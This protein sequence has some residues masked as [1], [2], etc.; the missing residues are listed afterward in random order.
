M[1]I[2]SYNYEQINVL[3]IIICY[4]VF[5]VLIQEELLEESTFVEKGNRTTP[6]DRKEMAANLSIQPPGGVWY[7]HHA[8]GFQKCSMESGKGGVP[9]R[10]PVLEQNTKVTLTLLPGCVSTLL[11][12]YR[13]GYNLD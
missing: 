5:K 12:S 6:A 3:E 10:V 1:D 11:C 4:S 13:E 9:C 7:P 8:P 2:A